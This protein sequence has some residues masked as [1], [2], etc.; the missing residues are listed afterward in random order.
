MNSARLES[1]ADIAP[2]SSTSKGDFP[3]SRRRQIIS[4]RENVSAAAKSVSVVASWYS[5][6]A[7]SGVYP[8]GFSGLDLLSLLS[9]A[10]PK[11]ATLAIY[12]R[13]GWENTKMFSHLIYRVLY[14]LSSL[15]VAQNLLH[16]RV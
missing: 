16:H 2:S 4:P 5:G 9:I 6:A 3:F 15:R 14:Q 7:H 10:H 8:R 11:S 1:G 12:W 13:S